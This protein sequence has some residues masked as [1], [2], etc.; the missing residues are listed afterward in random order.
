MSANA[1]AAAVRRDHTR[2]GNSTE[3]LKRAF[4]DSLI[5]EQGRF[6]AIATELDWYLA[7]AS[8]VRDRLVQRWVNTIQ[9]YYQQDVRVVGY[10]SRIPAGATLRQQPVESRHSGGG[11]ESNGRAWAQ[12]LRHH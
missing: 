8:S 3:L 1:I 2:T 11:R 10:F 12:C 5:Y 9:T 4:V 7:I 6:P